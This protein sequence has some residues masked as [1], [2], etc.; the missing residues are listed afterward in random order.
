MPSFTPPPPPYVTGYSV[1][2]VTAY[3]RHVMRVISQFSVMF[4]LKGQTLVVC[5]CVCV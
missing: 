5:V 1:Q 2:I 4:S 3:T